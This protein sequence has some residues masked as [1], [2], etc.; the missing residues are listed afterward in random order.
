MILSTMDIAHPY[1][2]VCLV[3]AT[4]SD[5]LHAGKDIWAGIKAFFGGPIAGYEK[6]V[7]KVSDHAAAKL[8]DAAK[9]QGCTAIIGIRK[10]YFT[11]AV[12]AQAILVVNI[13]GAGIRLL[14]SAPHPADGTKGAPGGDGVSQ[15]AG[16][17]ADALLGKLGS[18]DFKRPIGTIP[19][20]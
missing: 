3:N 14:E 16:V 8:I 10:E 15:T 12:K 19:G 7:Q 17:N 18:D 1:E 20:E 5:G 13:Y 4:A 11:I 2:H 9:T 6:A